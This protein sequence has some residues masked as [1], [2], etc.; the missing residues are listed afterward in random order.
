[1]PPIYI[2]Y[3]EGGQEADYTRLFPMLK[4]GRQYLEQITDDQFNEESPISISTSNVENNHSIES[5]KNTPDNNNIANIT[6][7]QAYRLNIF[8]AYFIFQK[9]INYDKIFRRILNFFVSILFKACNIP[10]T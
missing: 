7:R 8:H 1:M 9:N 10:I 5:A 4:Y 2:Y 6:P 3:T